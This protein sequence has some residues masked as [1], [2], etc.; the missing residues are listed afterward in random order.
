MP[1]TA[2]TQKQQEPQQHQGSKHS[3]PNCGHTRA[4]SGT[5]NR[6][7]QEQDG[8]TIREETLRRLRTPSSDDGEKSSDGDKVRMPTA[9]IRE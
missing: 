3:C 7:Q 5:Q 1:D 6:S 9:G 8:E 4:E 2:R